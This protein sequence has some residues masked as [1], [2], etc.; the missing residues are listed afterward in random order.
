M[1]Q[2][3]KKAITIIVIAFLFVCIGGCLAWKMYFTDARILKEHWNIILPNNI[4]KQYDISSYGALGDGSG[5][6]VYK[7][8]DDAA[9]FLG[10]MSSQKNVAMQDK[11]M[12]ILKKLKVDQFR[13]PDF[14]HDY[15]WRILSMNSDAR[16]K[17]YIIYDK[18][19]SL[20]YLIQDFY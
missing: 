17:L 4:E 13:Y 16:N 3:A 19:I 2:K 6:I 9:S 10:E 8:E 18:R 5:F 1:S 14:S 15:S 12:A 11:V 20:I 7:S